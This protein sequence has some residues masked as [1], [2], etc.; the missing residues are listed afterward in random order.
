MNKNQLKRYRK[1]GA[2]IAQFNQDL[3]DAERWLGDCYTRRDFNGAR[4]TLKTIENIYH[5][6]GIREV[7]RDEL[8]LPQFVKLKNGINEIKDFMQDNEIV[9]NYE[10]FIEE[11]I[12]MNLTDNYNHNLFGFDWVVRGSSISVS[13]IRWNQH[14]LLEC[15]LKSLLKGEISRIEIGD[16]HLNKHAH[17]KN[18]ICLYDRREPNYKNLSLNEAIKWL[19]EHYYL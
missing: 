5:E 17:F 11:Y 13:N 19:E 9:E 10:T 15:D 12:A 3:E 6:I 16:V 2:E 8:L 4:D 18:A 1:I 7:I 14:Q